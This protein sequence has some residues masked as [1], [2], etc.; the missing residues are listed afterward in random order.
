MRVLNLSVTKQWFDMILAGDKKEEYRVIK[1]YWWKRLVNV[2]GVPTHNQ[3]SWKNQL[4][5]K[6]D[7]VRIVNGYG[8]HRPVIDIEF[9]GLRIGK[10]I[11]GLCEEGWLDTELFIIELGDIIESKNIL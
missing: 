4:G 6:F 3:I 10:P 1:P 11:S 9:K 7:I 2:D 5:N 8:S